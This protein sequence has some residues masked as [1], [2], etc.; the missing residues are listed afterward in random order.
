MTKVGVG[1]KVSVG[2]IVKVGVS[3]IDSSVKVAVSAGIEGVLVFSE[4]SSVA[5]NSGCS[6]LSGTIGST[7]ETH[8]LNKKLKTIDSRSMNQNTKQ[9]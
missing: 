3:T 4:T 6:V 9:G 2:T 8:P 7:I 5:V 1:T